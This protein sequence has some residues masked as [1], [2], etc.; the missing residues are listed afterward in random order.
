[1]EERGGQMNP[2]QV[3]QAL[4]ELPRHDVD[5]AVSARIYQAAVSELGADE[6]GRWKKMRWAYDW[7]IEPS[8]VA[9]FGVLYLGWAFQIVATIKGV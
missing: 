3:D 1:M 6:R 5:P 9:G 4:S 8:A 2:K 7:V